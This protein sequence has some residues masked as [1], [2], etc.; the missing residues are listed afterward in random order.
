MEVPMKRI[1]IPILLWP[2]LLVP[3]SYGSDIEVRLEALEKIIQAQQK[4]IE[5]QQQEIDE[6]KARSGMN[7]AAKVEESATASAK[8]KEAGGPFK[9]QV[10]DLAYPTAPIEQKYSEGPKALEVTS[11]P[12]E[13]FIPNISFIVDG[14][15]IGRG[16]NDE[17]YRRL[18]V[19]DFIPSGPSGTSRGFNLR[20]G[21]MALYAPVDPYFDLAAVIPFSE[22]GVELE[23]AYFRTKTLPWGLQLK[24]GKFRSSFGRLNVQHRHVWDFAD[25]P[26][27]NRA[28]FGEDGL[29]EKGVHLNW[30]A[31]TPFYLLL[32]GEILQGENTASFGT[33]SLSLQKNGLTFSKDSAAGPN[34]FLGFL[35]SSV[36]MGSLSLLG[37]VSFAQGQSRQSLSVGSGTQAAYGDTKIYG[38]DLTAK[39]FID[40]YRY[41]SWQSEFMYR[42]MRLNVGYDSAPGDP[43]QNLALFDKSLNQS[44]FY[45]QFVY[46]FA[47]RW[48][49]G[50]RY[51]LLSQND[52][53]INSVT[54]SRPGDLNRISAMLEF[55]PTEFSTLRLQF[56][57]DNSLFDGDRREPVNSIFLQF[58]MAIGAHRA[59]AY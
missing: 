19:P 35:K 24:A 58:N 48:R 27:I 42:R 52:V 8:Q 56:N 53:Y 20:Y 50:I 11:F 21:E 15:F 32:G 34:L 18:T 10:K 12:Q 6:L 47:E 17:S 44:G 22:S 3:R 43:T 31:P 57:R 30:L 33:S 40:S 2:F 38:F 45:S 4:I 26:L 54:Q 55:K 46:R 37:G 25:G 39:Y 9:A 36:D 51:D 29:A 1:L 13:K 16:I 41:L 28:F 23:E 14:S 49:T 5:K 59:H 7:K